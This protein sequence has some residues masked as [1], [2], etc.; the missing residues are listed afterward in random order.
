MSDSVTSRSMAMKFAPATMAVMTRQSYQRLRNSLSQCW[1]AVSRSTVVMSRRG[2]S[3]LRSM[4]KMSIPFFV[5]STTCC[6]YSRIG[7]T[8][9]GSTPGKKRGE[10]HKSVS[11]CISMKSASVVDTQATG[12]GI[13]LVSVPVSLVP[14]TSVIYCVF[15]F[16][17]VL[18]S[19]L[20]V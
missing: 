8:A 2:A 7:L 11:S 17:F 10:S 15:V 19:L 1:M 14:N 18:A 6:M 16:G 4:G 9:Q 13:V 12:R 5:E 3:R 20:T